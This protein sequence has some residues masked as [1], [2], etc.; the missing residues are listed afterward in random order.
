LT[1]VCEVQKE[2]Y[3]PE[4]RQTKTKCGITEFEVKEGYFVM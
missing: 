2:V 3:L 1:D 4:D